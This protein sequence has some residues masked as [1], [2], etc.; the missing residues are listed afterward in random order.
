MDEKEQKRV[1]KVLGEERP[2]RWDF[3]P[4]GY[5]GHGLRGYTLKEWV[6]K[7]GSFS[8]RVSK[9]FIKAVH[10]RNESRRSA[11]LPPKIMRR[12]KHGPRI[13][14]LGYHH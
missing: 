1:E 6:V 5:Y 13:A 2:N 3:V 12:M 4:I 7:R 14:T 9:H 8:P 10:R 11:T